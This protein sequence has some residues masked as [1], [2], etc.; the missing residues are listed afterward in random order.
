MRDGERTHLGAEIED[1]DGIIEVVDL[2]DCHGC[3]CWT[4]SGDLTRI[5]RTF[6]W[7]VIRDK[8]SFE[9]PPDVVCLSAFHCKAST[10]SGKVKPLLSALS[11]HLLR[12]KA[13]ISWPSQEL[14]TDPVAKFFRPGSVSLTSNAKSF[15]SSCGFLCL[16]CGRMVLTLV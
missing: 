14:T 11:G 7:H 16:Y 5:T 13:G 15:Y 9:L 3:S 6:G 4:R 2:V 12:R 8:I 10:M 1:E